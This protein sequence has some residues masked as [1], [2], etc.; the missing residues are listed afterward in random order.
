MATSSS[1]IAHRKQEALQW[2]F[3][4]EEDHYIRPFNECHP[5]FMAI[6]IGHPNGVK[7]CVRRK[8]KL[9]H[10]PQNPPPCKG[11]PSG[12]FKFR[13]D[14]YDPDAP[15]PIQL[16]NPWGLD[17]RRVP[18][19]EYYL[20][21]GYFRVPLNYDGIGAQYTRTP[22][23][24]NAPGEKYSEYAWDYVSI[25][26]PKYDVTKLHQPYD[27]WKSAQAWQGRDQTPRDTTYFDRI[28]SGGL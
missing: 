3:G 4:P 12:V 10:N 17:E 25:P 2:T 23:P 16:A 13:P 19:E 26:P 14:L 8:D 20:R 6:P 28:V 11:H 5:D 27:K 9:G 1:R 22:A 21:N 24:E 15:A 18:N 7:I